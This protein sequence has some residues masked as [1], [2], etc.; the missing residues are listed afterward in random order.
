MVSGEQHNWP[1]RTSIP[2]FLQMLDR[3]PVTRHALGLLKFG[4]QLLCTQ[5]FTKEPALR[6][7]HTVV[8]HVLGL[9]FRFNPFSN[10]TQT[11]ILCHPDDMGY[12]VA[13]RPFRPD[14]FRKRLV[15]LKEVQFE[16]MEVRETRVPRTK[17]INCNPTPCLRKSEI[18]RRATST[19]TSRR[20]VTSRIMLPGGIA[21][22]LIKL[23]RLREN[24]GDCRSAAERLSAKWNPSRIRPAM[25]RAASSRP[26]FS[27]LLPVE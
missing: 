14:R 12:H 5:R 15:N 16:R 24:P 10:H 13:C 22:A 27:L 3:S 18:E 21:M 9:C 11:Q 25:S 23:L 20:S 19:L 17:V 2:H 26:I 8:S 4:P 1:P 7:L 6:E